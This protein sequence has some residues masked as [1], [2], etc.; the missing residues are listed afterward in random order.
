V[1]IHEVCT[2]NSKLIQDEEA[3]GE[4]CRAQRRTEKEAPKASAET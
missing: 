4:T 1:I 2:T 3:D